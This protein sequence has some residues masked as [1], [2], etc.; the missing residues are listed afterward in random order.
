MNLNMILI[1]LCKWINNNLNKFYDKE[2]D[3]VFYK[4]RW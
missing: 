4:K 2:N 3:S 1:N